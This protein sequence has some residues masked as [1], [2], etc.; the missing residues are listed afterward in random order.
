V[1]GVAGSTVG[2]LGF[3]NATSGTI[4][5]SP[6]AGALGTVTNTLQ[7]VADTFVY[8]TTTD[9]LTNKTLSSP[10]FTGTATGTNAI[11]IAVLGNIG[12]NTVLSNW[13]AGSAAVS[14]NTW[15]ACANDGS[16]AL[17]Y[18]N[19]TGLQC[20]TIAAG[21]TVTSVTCDGLTFTT[22]GT[23]PPRAGIANCTL[24]SS[25]ASNNLTVAIKD[26]AGN[27]PSATSPCA[28]W[29]RNA[30][31][32]TGTTILRTVT[33]ASSITVNAG[34]TF[35]VANSAT[36]CLAAA[37]CPFKLWAVFVDT[38]STVVVGLVDLTSLNGTKPLDES[39]VITTTACSACASATTLGT[40]Y[41]TAAQTNRPFVLGGFL[42]WGSGLA[43]AG[44]Y[45]SGP[46]TIQVMEPGIKK[47][48]EIVQ[49]LNVTTLTPGSTT[50]TTFVAVITQ[51]IT[52]TRASNLIRVHASGA[53][54]M[55]ASLS[56][57]SS[58]F[59]NGS[60]V[61]GTS[62]QMVNGTANSIGIN[63]AQFAYDV[64]GS[65]S[66]QTYNWSVRGDGT[67]AAVLCSHSIATDGCIMEVEEIQG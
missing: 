21:G 23:C 33:A 8:R 52:P 5:V 18:I 38:G 41:T 48:G 15:P 57:G 46:T 67:H 32:A 12:A 51:A 16:H 10:A 24:A 22:S 54:T 11:P 31:V 28:V 30:T 25:V 14:A 7:A 34:S 43:T 45:A 6:P 49:R 35:G 60:T 27:D 47:P 19:G 55:T 50:G 66:S 4:T 29:F 39:N 2:T 3:Q 40:V 44:T 62:A 26:N 65:T 58:A 59:Q 20:A 64:P 63:A 36:F 56:T 9:T 53:A 1:L 37:S 17:V 61:I 13:T 42:E